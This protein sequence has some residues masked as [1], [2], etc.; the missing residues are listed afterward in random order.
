MI[1]QLEQCIWYFPAQILKDFT[2][3]SNFKDV[4]CFECNGHN[5]YCD[6]YSKADGYLLSKLNTNTPS[7]VRINR[8]TNYKDEERGMF[9]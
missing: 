7:K 9:Y 6:R 3:N 4:G 8:Q 1:K 2:E 5:K